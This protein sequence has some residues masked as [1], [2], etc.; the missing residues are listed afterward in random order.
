[1][2]QA[3]GHFNFSILSILFVVGGC[4]RMVLLVKFINSPQTGRE[5][6]TILGN[7]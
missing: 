2:G 1:M 5:M 7:W 4:M 6:T 3:S